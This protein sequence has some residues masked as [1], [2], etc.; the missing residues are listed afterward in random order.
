M[1]RK[2][3]RLVA[4]VF[5][6]VKNYKFGLSERF[7]GVL[8]NGIKLDAFAGAEFNSLMRQ[9]E[10]DPTSGDPANLGV[11]VVNFRSINFSAAGAE[12][13]WATTLA[14]LTWRN[15]KSPER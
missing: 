1:S 9:A 7:I 13:R 8:L 3:D 11:V 15:L 5:A 12:P 2:R 14:Y 6:E 10:A 4:F